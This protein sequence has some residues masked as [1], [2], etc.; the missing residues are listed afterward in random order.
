MKRDGDV[1][2]RAAFIGVA[3]AALLFAWQILTVH[4]NYGGNWTALYMIGAGNPVPPSIAG[5][6]LYIFTNSYYDGQSFHLMA[7]DP[8][9]RRNTPSQL[10]IAPFR[11]GR[12]L[13]PALAWALAFG[14]DRWVD[15]AYFTVILA[16]AFLGSYWL[17][18][19][20]ARESLS[21]AWGLSFILSPATL[22]SIDRMTVDIALV[23]LCAAF[24]L[25]ADGDVE[26]GMDGARWKV[27]GSQ[28]KLTLVLAC[29]LLTRETGWLLF[30]AYEVYLVAR[31]RFADVLLTSVAAI[32]AVVWNLY[33]AARVGAA[34]TPPHVLGWIPLAGFID[35][36]MHAASYNLSP[37]L[38]ALAISLDY[39]ALAGIALAVVLAIRLA[40]RMVRREQWTAPGSAICAFTVA[41]IF[42]RGRAEW[43]DAYAFGRI[44]APLLLLIAMHNLSGRVRSLALLGLAPTVLV[45]SRI[46]LNLG[47]QAVGILHGWLH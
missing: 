21:P 31:R 44:F 4:Y 32:P 19:Y 29:A 10:E 23:A 7:H 8:W 16:F 25:Y 11:Y 34:P 39:V 17:A 35:R 5:E 1:R 38:N 45:D 40:I 26:S 36:F 28:W 3:A 2:A 9:M 33:I 41:F 6:R 43:A 42:L 14:R 27:S 30:A 46:A 37:G 13:V 20:A 22:T 18:M 15:S 47:K 12:I 24:A